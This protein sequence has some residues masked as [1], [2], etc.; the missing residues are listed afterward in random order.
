MANESTPRPGE[1]G[2]I[3]LTVPNAEA[4]RDFY[5]DVT[6]W[7]PAPVDMDG[8]QD[9]CMNSAGGRAVAGI[10]HARGHNADLPPVWIIYIVVAD[11]DESLRRSVA[12]GGKVRGGPRG[13]GDGARY[14]VIEDPAG[15]VAALYQP[16]APGV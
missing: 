12:G 3:D 13:M 10:C 9:F 14:C 2:W 1:I 7:T 15:A 4:V 11:L 6:G 16:A 8:Y 5:L